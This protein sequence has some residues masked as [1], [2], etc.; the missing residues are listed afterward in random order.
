[1]VTVY[2]SKLTPS[3]F[4]NLFLVKRLLFPAIPP[5]LLDATMTNSTGTCTEQ[6]PGIYILHRRWRKCC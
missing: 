3:G 6:R 2:D 4:D 1:M 5:E